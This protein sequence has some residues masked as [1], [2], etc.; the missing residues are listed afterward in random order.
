MKN[1]IVFTLFFLL[2][3]QFSF[4]Q[5]DLNNQTNRLLFEKESAAALN[6]AVVCPANPCPCSGGFTQMQ[7]YYFGVNN[8]QIQVFGDLNLT[9]SIASWSGVNGG[10][11]LTLSGA[12]QFGGILPFYI[13]LRVTEPGGRVCVTKIYARCPTNAWPGALDDLQVI[14]KTFG[15]FTVFSAT[16]L[17]NNITCD[18]SNV[19]Q[20]WRVGGNIVSSALNTLGTRNLE[21]VRFITNDAVRAVL[22]RT[23]DFGLG[24]TAPTARLHVTGNTLLAGTL[25][26]ADVTN[27]NSALNATASN[28]GALV[29]QGGAGIGKN[30]QIGNDLTVQGSAQVNSTT[31]S[32]AAGNGALVVAG[33]VGVGQNLN[34]TGSIS[35][36]GNGLF[37]GNVGIGTVSPL[38]KL[39]VEGAGIQLSTGLRQLN[40]RVDGVQNTVQ[41]VGANLS[42]RG[43]TGEHIYLNPLAGDGKV[44]IGT[45]NTPNSIG[46]SDIS[47][48]R[49]YVKGGILTDDL[50]VRTGWADYVFKSNYALMPLE[51]VEA[52]ISQHGHLPNTPA[53]AVVETDGISV[54]ETA[55]RQQEKIEEI[56]LH[57]IALNKQVKALE[58][59]NEALK[60]QI[61]LKTRR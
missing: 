44:G 27:I 48:Y 37:N 11:L 61:A 17:G 4:A 16:D 2:L 42:L 7:L 33:G 18:L 15:D 36:Q 51:S 10:Q 32:T 30:L 9:N 28:N 13:Y 39:H 14:G 49:L 6:S 23:G 45:A 34:A 20:D 26:V 58:A 5:S 22:T 25:N 57:L 1:G 12:G 3:T 46:G 21:D 60:A 50:R 31:V 43:T 41:S 59:E 35:A 19:S 40:W 53:E 8:A 24:N 54:G 52:Y 47:A 55:A 56:Y 29:V 38:Q